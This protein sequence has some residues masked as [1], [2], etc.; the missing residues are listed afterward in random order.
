[1]N[2][3]KAALGLE[4]ERIRNGWIVSSSPPPRYSD[5]PVYAVIEP[6]FCATDTELIAAVAKEACEWA[7]VQMVAE[8]VDSAFLEPVTHE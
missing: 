1:M 5:D 4:I 8:D 7:T 6:L 2:M 3:F